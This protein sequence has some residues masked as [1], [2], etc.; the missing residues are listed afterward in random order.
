MIKAAAVR[1]NM[2]E[3]LSRPSVVFAEMVSGRF[4]CNRVE[5]GAQMVHWNDE[6]AKVDKTSDRDEMAPCITLMSQSDVEVG[7]YLFPSECYQLK[8]QSLSRSPRPFVAR[9][10][11]HQ[12]P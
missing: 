12:L 3:V 10:H 2:M 9:Q 6:V 4:L 7:S 5:I 8:S 1:W 11:T